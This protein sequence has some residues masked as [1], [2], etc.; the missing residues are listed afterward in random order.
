MTTTTS[1]A[2]I[3]LTA[4]GSCTIGN[5]DVSEGVFIGDY[6]SEECQTLADSMDQ[7]RGVRAFCVNAKIERP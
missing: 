1:L 4:T 7:S 6:P 3:V 2:L 5:I